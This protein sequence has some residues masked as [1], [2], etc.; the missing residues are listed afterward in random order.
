MKIIKIISNR[1]LP[2]VAAGLAFASCSTD[3]V[4]PTVTDVPLTCSAVLGNPVN[5]SIVEN[6]F[7]AGT[8]I[9]VAFE[10]ASTVAQYY[11]DDDK[12]TLKP[13]NGNAAYWPSL[14]Q[15]C[16]LCAWTQGNGNAVNFENV[17]VKADQSAYEDFVNS[18]FIYSCQTVN[19]SQETN[20]SLQF[21]HQMSQIV[22]NITSDSPAVPD[23]ITIGNDD[24]KFSTRGVFSAGSAG[25]HYGT[26]SADDVVDAAAIVPYM[27]TTADGYKA[28][29]KAIVIPQSFSDKV[30][31]EV[32]V[33]GFSNPLRYVCSDVS[34]VG[35]MCYT[36]NLKISLTE[37]SVYLTD[38]VSTWLDG[39]NST[40]TAV[41]PE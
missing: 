7:D 34:W 31:F 26:W 33:P 39:D 23:R 13:R 18:D 14:K 10:T 1:V 6:T 17:Y 19:Y 30:L 16:V 25:T 32:T 4:A 3:E 40:A 24:N 22:I 36:Y 2:A 35:G 41:V 29:Y 12:K 20:P 27:A 28:T 15:D 37:L 5:R 38:S 8:D 21:Y 11:V 9:Y